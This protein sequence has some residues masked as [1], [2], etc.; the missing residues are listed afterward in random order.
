MNVGD[1]A[2]K[3]QNGLITTLGATAGGRP[4][5]VLEGSVFVGGAVVQWLRDEMRLIR[6]AE[7]SETYAVKAGTSNGV[8]I[9]PGFTGLG[10]PYWDASVR[11]TVVG[12]TR[13]SKKEHFIRAALESI[14]YQV[15]DIVFAMQ[16][17]SGSVLTRLRV[18]GGAS[19]N[20][21]LM[22]FQSDLLNCRVERPQVVETTAL[23][24]AY[25]AGLQTGYWADVQDIRRNAQTDT[26]FL[27]DADEQKR[28]RRLSGWQRAVRQARLK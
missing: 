3:S 27:P 6:T 14:A 25:L 7:E 23:G 10:A 13:G 2:V 19:A 8:Y 21:F 24:A 11:G 9:V 4:C 12:L 1:K 16:R 18:D 26:V 5:Y 22:Q 20:N 28:A 15:S 17:D